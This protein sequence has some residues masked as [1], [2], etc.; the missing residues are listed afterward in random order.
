[1]IPAVAVGR[2]CQA[3]SSSS[4]QAAVRTVQLATLLEAPCRKT[5]SISK[6]L[7]WAKLLVGHVR[8]VM[9]AYCLAYCTHM[10]GGYGLA[11]SVMCMHQLVAPKRW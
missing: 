9:L 4:D 1:M 7:R 5:Q 8:S 11:E 10:H 6:S 3:C 2:T